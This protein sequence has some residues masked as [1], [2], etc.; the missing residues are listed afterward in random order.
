M[1]SAYAGHIESSGS[2]K[3]GVAHGSYQQKL[4]TNLCITTGGNVQAVD[5]IAVFTATPK[6]GRPG[7]GLVPPSG[8]PFDAKA[9]YPSGAV[10]AWRLASA[11]AAASTSSCAP[12]ARAIRTEPPRR[13]VANRAAGRGYARESHP[14]LCTR[15]RTLHRA[16]VTGGIVCAA[17][18]V[19]LFV[20]DGRHVSSTRIQTGA[21]PVR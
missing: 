19:R 6:L 5:A 20:C 11:I 7:V 3:W 17:F 8:S 4:G 13:L 16:E 14:R 1:E 18:R 15:P 21:D 10:D 12:Q 9:E 2:F